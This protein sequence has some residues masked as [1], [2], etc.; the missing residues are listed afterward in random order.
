MAPR[1]PMP[2]SCTAARSSI[3]RRRSP[4]RASRAAL[5]HPVVV[6]SRSLR[7]DVPHIARS[8]S[9]LDDAAPARAR[10]RG[11][12]LSRRQR[13]RICRDARTDD[14]RR[15]LAHAR[16]PDRRVDDATGGTYG[17]FASV[18]IER[19]ASDARVSFARDGKIVVG[20]LQQHRR[21]CVDDWLRQLV[22]ARGR[23]HRRRRALS[24]TATSIEPTPGG[25]YCASTSSDM[26]WGISTYLASARIIES[27]DWPGTERRQS[28]GSDHRVPASPREQVPGCRPVSTA[29]TSLSADVPPRWVTIY[30][31]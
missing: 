28:R 29:R 10:R 5:A 20:R 11:P 3:A 2:P 26:R 17:S 13:R 15:S 24:S 21:F 9:A 14:R 30:C 7:P 25:D 4:L 16:A 12:E 6:R 23:Q 31:R 18:E 19:P 22:R 8:A 27:I 1:A